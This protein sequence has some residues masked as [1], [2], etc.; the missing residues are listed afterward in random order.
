MIVLD[1]QTTPKARCKVAT[2]TSS[3]FI[4]SSS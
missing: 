1:T 4:A 3:D 2:G